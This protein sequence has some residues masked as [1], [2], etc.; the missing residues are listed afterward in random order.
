MNDLYVLLDEDGVAY[1]AFDTPEEAIAAEERMAQNKS[2]YQERQ[3]FTYVM[4]T[5]YNG[6]RRWFNA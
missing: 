5:P 2:K 1:G 4:Q 6:T 3:P